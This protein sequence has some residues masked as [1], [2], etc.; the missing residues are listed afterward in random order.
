MSAVR[1]VPEGLDRDHKSLMLQVEDAL[2][3]GYAAQAF[4][5]QNDMAPSD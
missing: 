1:L 5:R 4:I 2:T 3:A